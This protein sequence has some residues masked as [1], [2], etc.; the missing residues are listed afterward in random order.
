MPI[1][2]YQPPVGRAI[3]NPDIQRVLDDIATQGE[4]Y[5][6]KGNCFG[7]IHI[8]PRTRLTIIYKEGYGYYLD[9][10][11]PKGETNNSYNPK[12]S[13]DFTDVVKVWTGR[14]YIRLP[15]AFFVSREEAARIVDTFCQSG[16]K[17]R[18]VRWVNTDKINWVFFEEE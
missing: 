1:L 5:W 11:I 16:K 15:R 8:G 18:I 10:T 12:T 4:D 14:A 13:D 9:M 3:G 6:G 17:D 2:N 7:L